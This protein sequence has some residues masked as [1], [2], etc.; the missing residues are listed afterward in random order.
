MKRKLPP[1]WL[2]GS[3]GNLPVGVLGAVMLVTLPQLLANL[4]VPE[5]RIATITAIGLAPTF[6]N[7]LFAPILDWRFNRRTYAVAFLLLGGVLQF[8]MLESLGNLGLLTI[9]L[10]GESLAV[11]LSRAALG[12]W[13]GAIV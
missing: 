2:M 5:P 10:F 9:L 12:G 6:F 11:C 7:F 3:L 1:V 13:L 4:H 8:A